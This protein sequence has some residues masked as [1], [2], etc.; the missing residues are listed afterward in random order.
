MLGLPYALSKNGT[1]LGSLLIFARCDAPVHPCGVRSRAHLN[2]GL[3]SAFGL[4]LLVK[5][6]DIIGGQTSYY[7]LARRAL[8]QHAAIVI[9]CIVFIK[10]F[11]VVR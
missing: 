5:C 3:A 4:Y 9:D 6:T 11:G 2:S 10:C 1:I 7:V 8:H